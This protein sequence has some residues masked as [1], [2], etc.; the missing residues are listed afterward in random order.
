MFFP[1]TLRRPR[2]WRS[3][4]SMSSL[5]PL[6][7]PQSTGGR[8]PNLGPSDRPTDAKGTLLS[9]TPGSK[10]PS[11]PPHP[12]WLYTKNYILYT[13]NYILYTIY[14][15]LYTIYCILYTIY[16]IR[17]TIYYIRYTIYYILYT[18]YYILYTIYYILYT[19]YYIYILRY[20]I[21]IYI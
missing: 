9:L 1:E 12:M 17:Y 3:D 19:I 6:R 13:I 8:G 2:K 7:K 14:Y 5:K 18:I 11:S 20:D 4:S 21:Y 10:R 15:I 16:Y